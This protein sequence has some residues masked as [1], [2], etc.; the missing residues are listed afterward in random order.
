MLSSQMLSQMWTLKSLEGQISA[1]LSRIWLTFALIL[2]QKPNPPR[3]GGFG[4]PKEE[5]RASHKQVIASRMWTLTDFLKICIKTQSRM[6]FLTL[7]RNAR[8]FFIL[9]T[10]QVGF[11]LLVLAF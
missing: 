4:V 11:E 8:Q 9:K 6:R 3:G 7:R 10:A 2:R 1:H 5:L